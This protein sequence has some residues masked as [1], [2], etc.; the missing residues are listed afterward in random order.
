MIEDIETGEGFQMSAVM[1]LAHR[2]LRDVEEQEGGIRRHFAV[3]L[4]EAGKYQHIGQEDAI[5]NILCRRHD[6]VLPPLLLTSP[7]LR[8]THEPKADC[9]RHDLLRRA[10]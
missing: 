4:G 2:A 3:R 5:I 9:A 7:A 6:P 1:S 10:G 8:L